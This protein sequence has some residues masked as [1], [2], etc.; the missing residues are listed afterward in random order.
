M[1]I[2]QAEATTEP[3]IKLIFCDED[4]DWFLSFFSFKILFIYLRLERELQQGG[5]READALLSRKPHVG[6]DP[7][8]PGSWAEPKADA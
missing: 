7:R 2:L 3:V 8:T 5:E 6:L 4:G 1:L